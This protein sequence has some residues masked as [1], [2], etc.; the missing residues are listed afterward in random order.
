MPLRIAL[1][2][3]PSTKLN[4][5]SSELA[6]LL[7]ELSASGLLTT[8]SWVH[9]EINDLKHS[10]QISFE[11]HLN[12]T[13]KAIEEGKLVQLST[14]THSLL[15]MPALKAA[16]LRIHPHA[17]LSAMQRHAG[18][19]E[20]TLTLA[21]GQAKRELS[22]VSKIEHHHGLNNQQQ[23]AAVY[24]LIIQLASRTHFRDLNIEL[25]PK[26][27]KSH[28]WF[29]DSHQARVAAINFTHDTLTQS[30]TSFILTQGTGY[31]APKSML[32][33]QQL[34]FILSGDNQGQ[35]LN[36]INKLTVQ[37]SETGL[38]LLPLMQANLS[39][40]VSY[41]SKSVFAAVLQASSVEA[42]LLEISSLK[43][44]LPQMFLE[45][46][47]Y[48]T[49]SGSYF[50]T[51]PLGNEAACGLAFVYPGV[52]TVYADMLSALHEYFPA[53]YARLEREGS[54]KSMLQADSIYHL[55]ANTTPAMD[56]GAQA[57]AGVG[58]SYLLTQLLIHEFAITPDFALGYSMGEASMWAS[59]GVW[60]NPH[61]LIDKTQ[62][63][64]LFTSAISGALTAVKKAWK[65]SLDDS[66]SD[67]DIVWNS[68]IVRSAP[69][70]I[71]ALLGEFPHAYLAIIQ[72]DTCVIAGCEAQCRAL[73]TQL[74]K[75][76]IAANR[77][78]AMHT[79]PAMEEHANVIKFYTQPL[80]QI[81]LANSQDTQGSINPNTIKFISAANLCG[82][83]PRHKAV[84]DGR[85]LNS[86][87]IANTIAD[88]FC[89]TLDF[90]A[91]IHSAQKQ[92]AKLFVEL[93]ADR[94][95]CTLI[96]KIAKLDRRCEATNTSTADSPCCTVPI[97]AKGGDDITTLLKALGQL[98]S[99]RVPLSVQ[100]L[101]EG[102]NREVAM[103]QLHRAHKRAPLDHS[104]KNTLVKGEVE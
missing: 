77:V 22:T 86:Q 10:N 11:E 62:T 5:Y 72:G 100:P 102:L 9:I 48:K 60:D 53:L 88:T 42:M 31:I 69:E 13:I 99:H 34:Q 57:I 23:F 95:N 37:L 78:T 82:K 8:Q 81:A 21:L 51:Y 49:P 54:L 73:L 4:A 50:T 85:P 15:M 71:Q 84:N 41:H 61:A 45:Q 38:E 90:T 91:L 25:G 35:L 52:G 92:G 28:Y 33:S 17:Q 104:S 19:G 66:D 1:L 65:R 43:Q 47:Q 32:N 79:T 18:S 56:L 63:D 67:N 94:Q 55:D 6:C 87:E 103:H 68:F 24:Q 83:T 2:V 39:D 58:S 59:L 3:L 14:A 64:P 96:D 89:H 46:D 27:A 30:A 74:G 98:I 16:Q 12:T 97:N 29:T 44:V 20:E 76:G 36:A 7:P 40:Y 26:Q 93:G 101:I 70:P 75:R 80:T